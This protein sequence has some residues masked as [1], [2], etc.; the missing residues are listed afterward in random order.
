MNFLTEVS[1]EKL[2]KELDKRAERAKRRKPP[3][4]HGFPLVIETLKEV[5]KEFTDYVSSN[6]YCPKGNTYNLYKD[7]IFKEAINVF[8]DE[9]YWKWLENRY[10]WDNDS[11]ETEYDPENN[12]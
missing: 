11:P 9:E 3:K 8:Y 4:I 2:L 7:A 6:A 12:I 1:T 10:T 5:V